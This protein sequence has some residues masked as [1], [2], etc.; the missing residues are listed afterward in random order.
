MGA[1][2][3]EYI[4]YISGAYQVCGVMAVPTKGIPYRVRSLETVRRG[5]APV[6]IVNIEK[7]KPE[8]FHVYGPR[9][10]PGA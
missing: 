8:W 1:K 5:R 10:R 6:R 4:I 2:L 3:A 9:E 7:R